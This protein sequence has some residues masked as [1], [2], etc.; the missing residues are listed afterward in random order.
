MR[1][2]ALLVV[3]A[4]FLGVYPAAAQEGAKPDVPVN[5]TVNLYR[6]IRFSQER[7]PDWRFVITFEDDQGGVYT[8]E[9]Y[10][11]SQIPDPANPGS[12]TENPNGAEKFLKQMNTTNFSTN[13]MT[14]RLLEH[15]E[16]HGK[17]PPST[18]VGTPESPTSLDSEVAVPK[19]K[20]P[21]KS[22]PPPPPPK[23]KK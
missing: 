18:V 17:I 14:K 20:P 7:K 15:L 12:F 13:S 10:G 3:C 6:I 11:P 5:K 19:T 22:V 8:D 2:L 16:L 9:H 21:V 23:V 4:L 1:R